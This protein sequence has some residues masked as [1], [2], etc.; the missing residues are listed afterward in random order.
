MEALGRLSMGE[1][2]RGS[3]ST[4]R[5]MALRLNCEMNRAS[6]RK[7]KKPGDTDKNGTENV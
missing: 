3:F 7:P 6:E 5:K 2:G 1:N 4:Q